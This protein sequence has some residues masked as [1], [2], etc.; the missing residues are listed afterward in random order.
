MPE[1]LRTPEDRFLGLKEYPFEPRYIEWQGLRM[2][3][4]DEGGRDLPVVLMLHG[5]PTWSYLY[6]RLIP[7]LLAAGY[8][9]VA[10]DYIGFGKSDKVIDD[11]WY[12]IE[13]HCQSIAH[14]IG[15]LDLGRITLMGQDWGG[16]IGLRQAVDEPERFARLTIMNTWLHHAEYAYT[17]AIR[18]WN[19]GWKPGSRLDELQPCGRVMGF[20]VSTH[21]G[22]T[23][24]EEQAF[25]AYEAPFPDRASKAGPRRFPLSLP[26]D[27]PEAGNARDQERC[28][29]K[30]RGWSK[31][32]H[33]IWGVRD[34]VF[35]EA[36]SE[37]WSSLYPQASLDKLAG[38][39]HFLQES[40]GE[41]VAK[42]LLQRIDE[43]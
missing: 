11:A 2:H 4:V 22:S 26:F 10:P 42:L 30:L 27:N 31:P 6:R 21:E 34:D 39:G 16:P 41:Q 14:L 33:F 38:A 8:R 28:F 23:L 36:W 19:A 25:E 17:D 40:H 24:S 32:I 5:M 29:E 12:S 35:N 20:Y 7:P 1:T 15:G 13:R 9:C 37:R 18:S 3:Y 43:E